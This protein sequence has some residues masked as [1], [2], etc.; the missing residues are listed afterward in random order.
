MQHYSTSE[1]LEGSGYY[2]LSQVVQVILQGTLRK[3]LNI[4]PGQ[5]TSCGMP[6]DDL[7]MASLCECTTVHM[8]CRGGT[9]QELQNKHTTKSALPD[10]GCPLL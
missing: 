4:T 10:E 6:F 2:L 7:V 5:L 1:E 9:Y 8:F 3:R